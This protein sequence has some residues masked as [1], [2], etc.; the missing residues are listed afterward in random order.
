MDLKR[1]D[2][3][4]R[5]TKVMMTMLITSFALP[6]MADN[7]NSEYF[8]EAR[9]L[10]VT[11]QIERVN[12]PRQECRTEYVRESMMDSGD[13]S[14]GG[15]IIGGVAGG[16]LGSQVGRGNGKVAAA[17]VGAGIGAIV[18]DRLGNQNNA[19]QRSYDRPVERCVSVD[20]WRSVERGYLVSYRYN[21]RD[22]NTV[23]QYRPGDTLRVRV[24]VAPADSDVVSY[25]SPIPRQVSYSNSD[26]ERWNNDRRHDNRR[27]YW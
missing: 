10:S 8:D 25:N 17:A 11:P 1:E 5:K 6:A 13:R 20:N 22:Y 23:T 16:L 24:A 27:R 9:V 26:D 7:V 18:G 15:T 21:G 19:S 2:L 4:M 14:L 3:K 12:Q